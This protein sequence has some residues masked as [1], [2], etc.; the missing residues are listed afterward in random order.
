MKVGDVLYLSPHVG[1]L[2]LDVGDAGYLTEALQ[3]K[4]CQANRRAVLQTA[5]ARFW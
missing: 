4:P 3:D 1:F 5:G 2:D